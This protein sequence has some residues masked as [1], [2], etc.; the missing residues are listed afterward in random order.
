MHDAVR[1]KEWLQFFVSCELQIDIIKIIH[2]GTNCQINERQKG[3]A[4]DDQLSIIQ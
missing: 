2:L 3:S 4:T 1:G